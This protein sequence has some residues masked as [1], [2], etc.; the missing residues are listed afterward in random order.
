VVYRDPLHGK[1]FDRAP[2]RPSHAP[3]LSLPAGGKA[4][5]TRSWLIAS[6]GLTPA[7][8]DIID[9]TEGAVQSAFV[10]LEGAPASEDAWTRPDIAEDSDV[11]EASSYASGTQRTATPGPSAELSFDAL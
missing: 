10:W 5:D 9:L 4:D 2:S 6:Y 1:Q 8:L 7:S 3:G 11:E